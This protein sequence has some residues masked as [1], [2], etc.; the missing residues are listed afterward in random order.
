[1]IS[2]LKGKLVY[3]DPSRVIMDVNGIGYELIIS[4]QTF[5][6][7]KDQENQLLLT[8]LAIREDAHILYGFST[9]TERT[10]FKQ[11]ISVSGIGPGTAIVMLSSLNAVELK[12][13]IV[14]SDVPGLQRIKGIG[15]KTA[16]RV[17]LDLADKLKKESWEEH[18]QPGLTSHN[19]NR[20]EALAALQT[21]G[22][23]RA[24]AEKSIDAVLKKSGNSITLEDL[25]KQALK[26]A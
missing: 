20:N 12:S 6:E 11:L 10:L 21:L 22:L 8:H 4:L 2:F 9:E 18:A 17:I 13:L 19:T 5:A 23:S 14:N 1:M 7:I 25:V 3:K 26:N 24:V 15:N 16:Q